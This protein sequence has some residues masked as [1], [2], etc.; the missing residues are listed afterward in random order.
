[1]VCHHPLSHTAIFSA[2]YVETSK[3][4]GADGKNFRDP[5]KAQPQ[6]CRY[7]ANLRFERMALPKTSF[8]KQSILLR[9]LRHRLR[10]MLCSSSLQDRLPFCTAYN[11]VSQRHDVMGALLCKVTLLV[12]T[13]YY[14]SS[15]SGRVIRF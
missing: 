9:S 3:L 13:R 2:K 4:L 12:F 10:S 5:E 8:P 11:F 15:F 14:Y 1:V 6:S 7:E